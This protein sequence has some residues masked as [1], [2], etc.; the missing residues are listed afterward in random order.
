[1]SSTLVPT[2]AACMAPVPVPVPVGRMP[3]ETV[4]SFRYILRDTTR[5]FTHDGIAAKYVLP[6][7]MFKIPGASVVAQHAPTAQAAPSTAGAPASTG[8]VCAGIC[9]SLI[10]QT[11]GTVPWMVAP[12]ADSPDGHAFNIAAL[13]LGRSMA[14]FGFNAV[15]VRPNDIGES[16]GDEDGAPSVWALVV[17]PLRPGQPLVLLDFERQTAVPDVAYR[18]E[19]GSLVRPVHPWIAEAAARD[20][21]HI[22]QSSVMYRAVMSY[23]C[24]FLRHANSPA[25]GFIPFLS[26]HMGVC[27]EIRLKLVMNTNPADGSG[28]GEHT[29]MYDTRT[30]DAQPFGHILM[31]MLVQRITFG[32]KLFAALVAESVLTEPY[33]HTYALTRSEVAEVYTE[34]GER[35]AFESLMRDSVFMPRW[36][37][38]LSSAAQTQV[39][40][41]IFDGK[42][43]NTV[44]QA[45][46]SGAMCILETL[47]RQKPAA[48]FVS[49]ARNPVVRAPTTL[50][51]GAP[52][53]PDGVLHTDADE[54]EGGLPDESELLADPLTWAFGDTQAPALLGESGANDETIY[55]CADIDTMMPLGLFSVGEVDGLFAREPE[56]ASL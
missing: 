45:E 44:Q 17:A 8:H 34:L 6:G 51:P 31:R 15:V 20:G 41:P 13:G 4:E 5:A 50:E 24:S 35:H 49:D 26:A 28:L 42:H 54:A 1:M 39:F 14:E 9:T 22:R 18:R 36:G 2:S 25:N 47:Y 53:V 21:Q 12:R 32:P 43:I 30:G 55:G 52:P 3:A 56:S 40:G 33:A 29:Y 38:P 19:D 7:V 23:T 46:R 27:M 48:W 16:L 11:D 10:A 37:M